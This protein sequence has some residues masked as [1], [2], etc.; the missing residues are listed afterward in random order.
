VALAAASRALF[1]YLSIA[2]LML[3]NVALTPRIALA[4]SKA[5]VGVASRANRIAPA[6]T[7]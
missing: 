3:A 4:P 2:Y 1:L 5:G 7:Q 6:R